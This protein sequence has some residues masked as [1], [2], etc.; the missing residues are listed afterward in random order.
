MCVYGA[1]GVFPHQQAI[2][3]TPAVCPTIQLSPD[4]IYLETASDPIG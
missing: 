4:I 2:L 3:G 1:G